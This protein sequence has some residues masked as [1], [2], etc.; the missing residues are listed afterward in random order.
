MT[1]DNLVD[2]R[3][4]PN[5]IVRKGIGSFISGDIKF[6]AP[7]EITHYPEKT[8]I[9]TEI[10]TGI[11]YLAA[12]TSNNGWKLNGLIE[13]DLPISANSLQITS[14]EDKMILEPL[15]E[16]K[17]GDQSSDSFTLAEFPLIGFYNGKIELNLHQWLIKSAGHSN[18]TTNIKTLGDRWNLQLEG[19]TL[20]IENNST[21]TENFLSKAN[22]ITLLL[23]LALGNSIIFNRQLYYKNENLV[24]E[25]W[26]RKA[27][28]HFG[29]EPCI[30]ES[31]INIFLEQSLGNFENWSKKKKDLF[32]STVN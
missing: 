1:L 9:E 15:M 16:V 23:S 6:E 11:N 12:F 21:T 14:I 18:E 19:L 3:K 27:G 24:L 26:R 2:I 4:Y 29:V 7:F 31:Q 8:I 17:F 5:L 13:Q 10:K 25:I 30:S 20:R 32:Y 22:N 28:Y